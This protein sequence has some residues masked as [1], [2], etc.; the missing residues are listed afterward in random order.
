MQL[1]GVY[2]VGA[3]RGSLCGN[4]ARFYRTMKGGLAFPN[5][6]CGL[7][8]GVT[9]GVPQHF[10]ATVTERSTDATLIGPHLA[11]Q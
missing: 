1:G 8:K 2:G 5:G 11:A 6:L 9:H 10:I 4:S 7:A 3:I